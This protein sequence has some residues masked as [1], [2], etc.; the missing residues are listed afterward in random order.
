MRVAI[1]EVINIIR[2]SSR[3]SILGSFRRT[4]TSLPYVRPRSKDGVNRR[5]TLPKPYDVVEPRIRIL[6]L[7]RT[8]L[9][10]R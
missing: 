7:L 1:E 5:P 4:F 2:T 9:L 8:N 3:F 10:V 6:L